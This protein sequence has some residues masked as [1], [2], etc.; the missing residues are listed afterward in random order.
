V[1]DVFGVSLRRLEVDEQAAVGA[2]ILGGAAVGLVDPAT[3][4]TGWARLGV[5][6]E[7]DTARHARYLELV[8]LFRTA[9]AVNRAGFTALRRFD[10]D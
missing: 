2:C 1:A 7:P 9:Y 5:A 4:S 6:V 8:E 10:T 3:A